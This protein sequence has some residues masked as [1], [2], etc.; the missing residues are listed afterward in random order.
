MFGVTS[1]GPSHDGRD[2]SA[3]EIAKLANRNAYLLPFAGF[4]MRQE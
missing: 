2:G 4:V 3:S 1:I